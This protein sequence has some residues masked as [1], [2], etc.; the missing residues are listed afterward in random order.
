MICAS[1]R[2]RFGG[3]NKV[4]RKGDKK[5]E[6]SRDGSPRCSSCFWEVVEEE[7][8]NGANNV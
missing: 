1:R 2:G 6:K 7:E 3:K 5:E 8:E 4:Y